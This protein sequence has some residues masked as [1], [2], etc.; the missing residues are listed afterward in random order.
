MSENVNHD[1]LQEFIF[2]YC[3]NFSFRSKEALFSQKQTAAASS[4]QGWVGPWG[5]GLKRTSSGKGAK[6]AQSFADIITETWTLPNVAKN[7]KA[8]SSDESTALHFCL[9]AAADKSTLIDVTE[10]GRSVGRS[11]RPLRDKSIPSDLDVIVIACVRFA[12]LCERGTRR[13]HR[14]HFFATTSLPPS[15][16]ALP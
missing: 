10:G 2:A 3:V 1:F 9:S 12:L 8:A 4:G 5:V 11:V 7:F 6:P 14:M 16:A 13:N 15:L